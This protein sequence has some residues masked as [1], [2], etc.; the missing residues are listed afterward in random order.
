MYCKA[1]LQLAALCCLFSL[2]AC[3]PPTGE[4]ATNFPTQ[5]DAGTIFPV[6]TR[7]SK[8]TATPTPVTILTTVV[9]VP[10]TPTV[11]PAPTDAPPFLPT[12]PPDEALTR[13]LELYKTN[14]GCRLPCWWGIVPGETMWVDARYL[15]APLAGEIIETPGDNNPNV[16][17]AYVYI[18]QAETMDTGRHDRHLYTVEHGV[19]QMIEAFTEPVS[20]LAPGAILREYGPPDEVFLRTSSLGRGFSAALFYQRNGFVVDWDTGDAVVEDGLVKACLLSTSP[21]VKVWSAKR[22]L[23]YMDADASN[24]EYA[25]PLD[26]VTVL[27][28]QT[29]HETFSDPDTPLC[30][31]TP[32]EHWPGY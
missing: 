9:S 3:R 29:F 24:A 7:T 5:G 25:K 11:A 17:S 23:S 13:V 26:E 4:P 15:L 2:V 32:T 21:F 27:N 19:V 1:I 16:M 31:E 8:P 30:L 6:V 20:S 14:G 10:P 22:L 18:P 28:I 12:L